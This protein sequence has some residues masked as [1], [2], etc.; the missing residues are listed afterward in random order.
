MD[1]VRKVLSRNWR[2]GKASILVTVVASNGSAPRKQ[3]ACMV[4]DEMGLRAGSVG[5]GRLEYQAIAD[6]AACLVQKSGM[7]RPYGLRECDGLDMI[8][9][10]EVYLLYTYVGIA[11]EIGEALQLWQSTSEQVQPGWLILPMDGSG[12]G[13]L[14]AN[15]NDPVGSAVHAAV[16]QIRKVR[17]QI[18]LDATPVNCYVCCLQEAGRV[19]VFGGGHLAQE[20]VPLLSHVGFR[21]IV[22][23]DREEF[24]TQQRFPAAEAVYMHSFWDLAGVYEIVPEDYIIGVTRGHLGDFAVEQFAL[25]SPAHY[26]GMVGSQRKIAMLNEKLLAVGFSPEDL[27]RV[28]SPIG[29]SIGS[30]TPAEIAISIAAQLIAIRAEKRKNMMKSTVGKYL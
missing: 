24:S 29:L 27:Q 15:M 16:Q 17:T 12:V 5:G 20:L 13:F 11:A 14:A 25:S 21:C 19:F 1:T 26:I 23:D 9:G 8:C 30:E 3:G 10:G 18:V 6:A 4:V 2:A 22:T 28:T 7:Q